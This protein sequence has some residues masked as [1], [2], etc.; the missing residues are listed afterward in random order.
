MNPRED[1]LREWRKGHSKRQKGD[2]M[3]T[4]LVH[5]NVSVPE[6]DKRTADEIGGAILDALDVG[7]DDPTVENLLVECPL[8]EEAS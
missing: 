1:K 7:S 3:R 5:L 6:Y 4:V 8:V 2:R